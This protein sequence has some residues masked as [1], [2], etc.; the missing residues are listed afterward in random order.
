VGY[1]IGTYLVCVKAGI[2]TRKYLWD[3][4]FRN[5][6]ATIDWQKMHSE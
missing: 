2:F 6:S 4:N 3:V 5:G 1:T